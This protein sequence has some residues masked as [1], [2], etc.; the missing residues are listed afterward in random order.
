MII[1]LFALDSVIPDRV[2][3]CSPGLQPCWVK[4]PPAPVQRTSEGLMR[5]T[6]PATSLLK[7]EC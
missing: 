2:R 6:H 7:A 1:A 4:K 3:Y 5:S